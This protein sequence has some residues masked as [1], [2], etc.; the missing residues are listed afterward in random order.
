MNE[1]AQSSGFSG[2]NVEGGFDVDRVRQDFPI[3]GRQVH[4]KPLVYFDSGASA[5]K[6]RA[7]IDAMTEVLEAQYTNVHRGAHYLSQTLTDRYEGVREKIAAFLNAPSENE[8]VITR[9][10]TEAINLV[11]AT[12]G[13]KFLNKG[14]GVL[15]S[16]MEHHANIV[17]WQLL[18][19]EIGIELKVAPIDDRGVL[20]MDAYAALLD[21]NT[22][23]VAMTHCSN[24]LG[25][26]LPGKEIV[27]LAHERGIPVLLDGSQAVV[28]SA[29][30]V[31][32]LNADFYVFTGHKLYGPTAIGVLYG[33]ADLLAQMPP[34]QGGG[35]MIATVTYEKTTYQEPPYRFEA[36]TPPIVEAIGLGAAID[37]VSAIG[38]DA[39]A[40]HEKALLA[41]ATERLTAMPDIRLFGS[42]PE[43]AAILS[44]VQDGIHPFDTAATLDRAG[45]AVRVGQHCAEPLMA[46][47][48][49]DG[50]V[51]ASLAMYNTSGE[52]DTMITA[53]ERARSLFG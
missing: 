40:A 50:T 41:Y 25:T 18:R 49:V 11:A 29:V 12:Y 7:V 14:D 9:N 43:K 45:V 38:M 6:P 16:D 48:G 24:V 33:K 23:L 35:D 26:M 5:Q 15:I 30:D 8:I 31:Q 1:L 52:I 20:D 28:H 53:L 21:G 37:Y 13:R 17:P 34:Y 47:L 39:I 10:T 3:L 4:G 2:H 22:K 27:R 19:D 46:R 32:D 42:A 51:R 36:G 44:F